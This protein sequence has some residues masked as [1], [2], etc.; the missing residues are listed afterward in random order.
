MHFLRIIFLF[1]SRRYVLA[2]NTN[3]LADNDYLPVRLV[4]RQ[5]NNRSF[6]L[7]ENTAHLNIACKWPI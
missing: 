1:N 5:Q 2:G 4:F 7:L 6:H 3:F